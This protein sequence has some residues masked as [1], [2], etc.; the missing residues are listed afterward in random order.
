MPRDSLVVFENFFTSCKL[1]DVLYQNH[2]YSIGTV[3][4]TRKGLSQFMKEKPQ[5]KK[6]KLDK[7]EFCAQTSE[8]IVAIKWLDAKEVTVLSSAHKQF[9]M[10]KR[11]HKG[12]YA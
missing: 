7:Y 9:T 2:I 11:T 1:T 4:K 6:E 10:V 5:N 8:S 3:R 12:W